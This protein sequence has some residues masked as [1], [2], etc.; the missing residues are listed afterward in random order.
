VFVI[1]S[2]LNTKISSSL[3]IPREQKEEEEEEIIF[4][5]LEII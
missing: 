1:Y 3:E 4:I 5:N 2:L